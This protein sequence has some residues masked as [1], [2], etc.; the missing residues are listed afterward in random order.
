[1]LTGVGRVLSAGR[2]SEITLLPH[3]ITNGWLL[4]KY[5]VFQI[6]KRLQNSENIVS[7]QKMCLYHLFG[8]ENS[9]DCKH[10]FCEH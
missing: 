6:Y 7:V 3:G 1:M 8:S 4:G 9:K 2:A 5:L 10:V